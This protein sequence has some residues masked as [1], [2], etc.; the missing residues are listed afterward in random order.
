MECAGRAA[1]ATALFHEPL[2]SKPSPPSHLVPFRSQSSLA[3]LV[4]WLLGCSPNSALRIPHSALRLPPSALDHLPW[5]AFSR[6]TRYT[7]A[8]QPH[9]RPPGRYTTR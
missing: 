7:V 9:P 5:G 6:Y 8:L 3:F 4:A 1:A 2:T